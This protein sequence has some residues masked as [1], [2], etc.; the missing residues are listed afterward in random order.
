MT[1]DELYRKFFLNHAQEVLRIRTSG[2]EV[3]LLKREDPNV[4][5]LTQTAIEFRCEGRWRNRA[6]F[7]H[8]MKKRMQPGNIFQIDFSLLAR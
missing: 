4:W 3:L 5:K 6:E 2:G 1:F 8:L 7:V